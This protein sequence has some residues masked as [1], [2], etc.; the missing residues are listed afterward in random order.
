MLHQSMDSKYIIEQ[1]RQC[2]T[3]GDFFKVYYD[4]KSQKNKKY[5]IRKLSTFLGYKTPSF[6]SDVLRGKRKFNFELYKRILANENFSAMEEQ[7]LLNLLLAE[8]KEADEKETYLRSNR[9]ILEFWQDQFAEIPSL[10][11]I[12]KIIIEF[13]RGNKQVTWSQVRKV[14]SHFFADSVVYERLRFLN[15]DIGVIERS[16]DFL[17]INNDKNRKLTKLGRG[18]YLDLLPFLQNTMRLPKGRDNRFSLFNSFL[19]DEEFEEAIGILHS[20]I[21]KLIL[22]S[23]RSDRSG[24]KK[25]RNLRVLFFNYTTLPSPDRVTFQALEN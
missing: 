21:E 17:S 11:S 2:V 10:S 8:G 18:A 7:F 12:D 6:V 20:A 25:K 19:S 24:A 14:F 4:F 16:G 22:L 5:S 9:F 23:E 13:I 15:R 1:L 3:A